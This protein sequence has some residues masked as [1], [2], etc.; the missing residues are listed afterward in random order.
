MI[1]FDITDDIISDIIKNNIERVSILIN[2]KTIIALLL[3][4]VLSLTS[5]VGFA[6]TNTANYKSYK[7]IDWKGV[8][9]NPDKFEGQ[10]VQF[11]GYVLQVMENQFTSYE[12]DSGTHMSFNNYALRVTTKGKYDDVV[13]VMLPYDAV[14]GGGRL[15]EG[16]KVTIYG[17][18]DGLE[19]YE[20][21]FGAS[22]TLPRISGEYLVIL[23]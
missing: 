13:Y 8:S 9:R 10:T 18:Y 21:I 16:D 5:V 19:T 17:T 3:V 11:T 7:K 1:S 12:D 20:T 23:D 22:V 4:F 6:A 2:K 14:E 15:L